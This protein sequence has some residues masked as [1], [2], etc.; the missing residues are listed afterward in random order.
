MSEEYRPI[1]GCALRV[2]FPYA[3]SVALWQC[4]CFVSSWRPHIDNTTGS[5]RY[6]PSMK[7]KMALDGTDLG[8]TERDVPLGFYQ[9]SAVGKLGLS[10]E[11]RAGL[12]YDIAHLAEDVSAGWH[13]ISFRVFM[14]KS[15]NGNQAVQTLERSVK[16]V[17]V[18]A[19]TRT[20]ARLT[21]GIRNARVLTIL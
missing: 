16:T 14:E 4:S 12:Y 2:Y 10:Y 9:E 1:A 11:E 6:V 20:Y 18:A 13:D 21:A 19:A 15:Q 8:H 7:V 17:S 3:V 5:L